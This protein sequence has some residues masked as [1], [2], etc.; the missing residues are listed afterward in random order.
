MREKG[1][2]SYDDR[3]Y[4]QRPCG[5]GGGQLEVRMV[6]SRT[7]VMEAAAVSAPGLM[8]SVVGRFVG[9]GF[10]VRETVAHLG[11][12]EGDAQHQGKQYCR[13]AVTARMAH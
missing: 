7:R 2:A 12:E 5:E 3:L 13:E 1:S 10:V 6:A 4:Q 8:V 11:E 9:S